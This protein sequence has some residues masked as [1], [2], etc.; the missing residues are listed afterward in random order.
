MKRVKRPAAVVITIVAGLI[1]VVAGPVA[2]KWVY[3]YMTQIRCGTPRA[4]GEIQALS[5]ALETYKQEHGGY[6]SNTA[7]E[8]LSPAQFHDPAL[9][10]P[11]SQFLYRILSGDNDG[12]PRIGSHADSKAYFPFKRDMIRMAPGGPYVVDPWGNAYGYST[13][14]AKQPNSN[15]GYNSG[16]F[17]LWST[18]GTTRSRNQSGWYANWER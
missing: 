18:G 11:A 10:I 6:P 13:L 5:A 8:Q 14:K 9:Y 12:D 4:E 15:D 16:G 17:D 1:L 7:T 2:A 3:F